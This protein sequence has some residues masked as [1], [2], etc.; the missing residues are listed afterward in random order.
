M[1]ITNDLFDDIKGVNFLP[2]ELRGS[3][4]NSYKLMRCTNIISDCID[5][6]KSIR[7]DFTFLSKLILKESEIPKHID[8][9]FL[10]GWDKYSLFEVIVNERIKERL[11]KLNHSSD[12]LIFD[13]LEV[14]AAND[15]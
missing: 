12:F 11:S 3:Y 14:T 5:E 6:E 2:L 4:T 8:A 15:I 1:S 7:K 13:R 9:F 10:S